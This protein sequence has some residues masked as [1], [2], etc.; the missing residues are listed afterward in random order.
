[1]QNL[2]PAAAVARRRRDADGTALQVR[3]S[4]RLEGAA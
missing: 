3:V 4:S 2:Q 1:L